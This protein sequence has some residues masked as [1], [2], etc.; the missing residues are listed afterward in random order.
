[1]EK[2]LAVTTD[3]GDVGGSWGWLQDEDNQGNGVRQLRVHFRTKDYRPGDT[4]VTVTA[5]LRGVDLG[6]G[7]WGREDLNLNFTIVSLSRLLAPD[8]PG[9]FRGRVGWVQWV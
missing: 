8:M 7:A 4:Q 9:R 6:I 5:T 3:K 1:M 2:A